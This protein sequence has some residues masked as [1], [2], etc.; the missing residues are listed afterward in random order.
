MKNEILL[1]I[2]IRTLGAICILFMA[3]LLVFDS[4]AISTLPTV[5]DEQAGRI[6]RIEAKGIRYATSGERRLH[7]ILESGAAASWVCFVLL[8]CLEIGRANREDTR[9]K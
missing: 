9:T 8:L 7:S 1:R 3:G 6:Y 2:P 5:A 4:N